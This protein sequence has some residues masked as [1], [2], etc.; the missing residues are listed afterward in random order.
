GKGGKTDIF[1]GAG[2]NPGHVDLDLEINRFGRKVEAGAEFFFSQP[3]YDDQMLYDF[4]DRTEDVPKVPFLVG[5]LPLASYK[6]AE[7][8][9]N[10][11]PGMQIP[12][13]VRERL[14]KAPTREAQ[15]EIGIEVAQRT[16]KA[17]HAHPRV[18]GVYIY[19]PFG[20]YRAVL[21]V[22]EALGSDRIAAG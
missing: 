11:V 1:V 13:E 21:R 19:P 17:V 8:L 10:E 3:L 16:L 6:N 18:S 4:L 22:A 12:A 9:H 7:F 15:R 2:C 5:I 20:S 14:R